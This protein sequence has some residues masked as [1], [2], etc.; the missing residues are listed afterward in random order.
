MGESLTFFVS[1]ESIGKSSKDEKGKDQLDLAV[2]GMYPI[3]EN[4]GL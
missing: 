4:T 1:I 2:P 3:C